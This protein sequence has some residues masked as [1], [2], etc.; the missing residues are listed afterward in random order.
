[1]RRPARGSSIDCSR[2]ACS[3]SLSDYRDTIEELERSDNLFA[4]IVL[5]HLQSQSATEASDRLAW[6]RRIMH[7]L[8]ERNLDNDRRQKVLKL[9]DWMLDLPIEFNEVFWNEVREWKEGNVMPFVTGLEKMLMKEGLKKGRQQG[10]KKGHQQGLEKGREQGRVEGERTGL[11][12]GLQLVLE[13]NYNKAGKMLFAEIKMI[14]L[15]RLKAIH[16]AIRKG[17][18]IEELRKL[19]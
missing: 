13:L 12:A 11:L 6:K 10:L 8:M 15:A 3:T 7:N 19:V 14:P 5:A 4:L 16:R 17:A 2:C 9:V 18:T 1:M